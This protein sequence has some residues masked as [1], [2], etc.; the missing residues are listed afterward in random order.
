[1]RNIEPGELLAFGGSSTACRRSLRGPLTL[2]NHT[3]A[4]T[5]WL[6]AMIGAIVG[7]DVAFLRNRLLARLIANVSIVLLFVIIYLIFLKRP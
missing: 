7:V 3:L 5:L 4:L 6:V 1:M 2:M